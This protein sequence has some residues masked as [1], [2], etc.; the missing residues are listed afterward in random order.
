MIGI[1]SDVIGIT[2]PKT[3]S[4]G[5]WKVQIQ[6]NKN[7]GICDI[8]LPIDAVAPSAPKDT[9]NGEAVRAYNQAKKEYEAFTIKKKAMRS[10][11]LNYVQGRPFIYAIDRI[12]DLC[13]QI[14]NKNEERA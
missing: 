6:L 14:L 7:G 3:N 11:I 5:N 12:E 2:I 4:Q 1:H 10:Q 13:Y 8:I 9:S